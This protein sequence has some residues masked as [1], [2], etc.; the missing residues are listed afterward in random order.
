[1]Q[2]AQIARLIRN[3]PFFQGLDEDLLTRLA[4]EARVIR[5]QKREVIFRKGEPSS[6]SY[7]IAYGRVRQ[8]LFSSQGIEKPLRV[9]EA[10]GG[11]GDATLLKDL[12]H[13][14][15]AIALEDTALVF[16]PKATVL[17]LLQADP[18]L[19][20]RLL[21]SLA[22]RL[23][24]AA[25]DIEEFFMHPPG[26]RLASYLLRLVPPNA[27]EVSRVQLSL[28]KHLM[29]AQL[30]LTPE[31]LSR[32]FREFCKLGLIELDGNSVTI[33]DVRRLSQHATDK[34]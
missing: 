14:T 33:L 20:L 19:T 3:L 12:A 7:V 4:H 15:T 17:A 27:S 26:A 5:V 30:N 32:Y 22:G 23:H 10:G 21:C 24:Q 28:H 16:V 34:K 8:S 6:G 1:M 29:A 18:Q 13:N 31:T 9:I 2:I 25:V 11:F